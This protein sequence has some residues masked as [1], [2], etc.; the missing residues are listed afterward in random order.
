VKI[1]TYFSQGTDKESWDLDGT[2]LFGYGDYFRDYLNEGF[3]IEEI[4][5]CAINEIRI[6]AFKTLINLDHKKALEIS[7]YILN[8]EIIKIDI[9]EKLDYQYHDLKAA[10]NKI[11]ANKTKKEKEQKK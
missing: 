10:I 9:D 11:I 2:S 3:S 4:K 6:D 1:F 8:K 7:D 5:E